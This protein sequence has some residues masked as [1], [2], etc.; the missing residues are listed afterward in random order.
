[1][2]QK[3]ALCNDILDEWCICQ[4]EWIYLENIFSADDI[5]KQLPALTAKFNNVDK[6]WREW[7]KITNKKPI[8]LERCKAR[9]DLLRFRDNNKILDSINK[10]LEKYL[11]TKRA[12]FPRFC[13]LSPDEL[14]Q[15]LSESRN[16]HAVQP[17]LKKCFD[18]MNKII[19]TEEEESREIIAMVSTQPE[20]DPET[21]NFTN[22]IMAEG[23]VESWMNSI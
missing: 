20:D 15:I 18:N 13:F 8:V 12:K 17:H 21:V 7:M 11:D 1:M 2:G 14:I 22:S 3:L 16:P 10:D 23:P 4:K 19:F 9:S 6:F 5:Q